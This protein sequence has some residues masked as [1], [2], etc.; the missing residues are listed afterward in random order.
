MPAAR[1]RRQVIDQLRRLPMLP[2]AGMELVSLL[3]NPETDLAAAAKVI[4]HDPGLTANVLRLANSSLFGGRGEIGSAQDALARV[5]TRHALSMILWSS[6]SPTMQR[7]VE[8]YELAAGAL[9][10]HSVAVAV[11]SE[12]LGVVLRLPPAAEVF[13]AGLLH[14]VGK[15][16]L[17][18]FVQQHRGAI[19]AASE[20][21]V[22]ERQAERQVMGIDHA[23][24]GGW[25]AKRWRL[26]RAIRGVIRW[27]HHPLRAPGRFREAASLI[28]VA[29]CAASHLGIG[30]GDGTRGHAELEVLED[31]GLSVDL[32]E[33]AIRS[34]LE[35]LAGLR[36]EFRQARRAVAGGAAGSNQTS[37]RRLAS[38]GA[39]MPPAPAPRARV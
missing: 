6:V 31:L 23:E 26:P 32:L 20:A 36:D 33:S 27:H 25:L 37:T 18:A 24:A 39:A 35:H 16:A 7:P 13:S 3:Q 30:S 4:E 11:T 19:G 8:G 10:E 17:G 1:I 38:R 29:D 21:G 28:H 34:S 9:W 14:D 22:P 5:G 15:L 2:A 12:Q